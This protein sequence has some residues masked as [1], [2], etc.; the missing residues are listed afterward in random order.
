MFYF[1]KKNVI[2]FTNLQSQ[3]TFE[4]VTFKR[5]W[6]LNIDNVYLCKNKVKVN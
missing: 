5:E 3:K 2:N 6:K 1:N 4:S